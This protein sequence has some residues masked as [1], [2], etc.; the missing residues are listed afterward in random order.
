MSDDER[1]DGKVKTFVTLDLQQ[2]VCIGDQIE[3]MLV[4]V[5][6]GQV[7]LGIKAPREMP[8]NRKPGN[9]S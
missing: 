1:E 8:I 4:K 9:R 3:V 5:S 6:R 2:K 7:G